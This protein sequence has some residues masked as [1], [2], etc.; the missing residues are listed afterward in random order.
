MPDLEH[1]T[2]AQAAPARRTRAQR[3]AVRR[4]EAAL[5]EQA[6]VG[7]LYARSVGTSAEQSAHARL[8]GASLRVSECD[9]RAK[10][11]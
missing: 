11:S 9:R 5:T 1:A 10:T 6:R 3:V 2:V 4:L 8:Q 7:D